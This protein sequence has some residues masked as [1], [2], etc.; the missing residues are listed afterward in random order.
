M[1]SK[2]LQRRMRTL[3]LPA[4]QDGYFYVDCVTQIPEIATTF[5]FQTPSKA[6][7]DCM[8]FKSTTSSLTRILR[9]EDFFFFF[10][11]LAIS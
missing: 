2:I 3:I 4:E 7:R 10:E 1:L 6:R 8:V 5:S 9:A 11:F